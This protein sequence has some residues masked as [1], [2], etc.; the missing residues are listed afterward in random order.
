MVHRDLTKI[1]KIKGSPKETEVKRLFV[2]GLSFRQIGAKCGFH[3]TTVKKFIDE[4]FPEMRQEDE[5]KADI[6]ILASQI[7]TTLKDV[8]SIRTVLRDRALALKDGSPRDLSDISRAFTGLDKRMDEKLETLFK[9]T[10]QLQSIKL[11]LQ[12]VNVY[13]SPVWNEVLDLVNSIFQPTQEQKIKLAE[14]LLSLQGSSS[15]S[16]DE[17][18]SKEV[19]N[20]S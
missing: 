3:H 15:E 17:S 18:S 10:H 14:G 1:S 6:E 12:Q 2:K 4:A 5:D 9:L 7:E 11:E 13:N 19:G 16:R 20:G 8:D